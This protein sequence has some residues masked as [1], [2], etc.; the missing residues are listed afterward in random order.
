MVSDDVFSDVISDDKR[1][2]APINA[3]YHVN[4]ILC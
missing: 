3:E 4:A 2:N 1:I